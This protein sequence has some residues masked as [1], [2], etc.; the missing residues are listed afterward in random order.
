MPLQITD[1]PSLDEFIELSWH[2]SAGDPHWIPPMRARLHQELIGADAFGEYGRLQLFGCESGGRLAGRIVAL[3]NPRLADASGQVVGQVG[4]FEAIDDEQVAAGLFGAA[5]EWLRAAGAREVWG[6][7]NGGAHRT[8]RLMTSGFDRRPYLFE[9]RNPPYYP[10]LFERAGFE[11][12][13]SWY[14]IDVSSDQL[15]SA[16]ATL[17][18]FQVPER[19]KNAYD[20]VWLDPSD[21]RNV[22]SRLH[23]L[24]DAMWSGHLGYASLD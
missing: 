1:T 22:L 6:P 16:I 15:R 21:A 23:A 20:V 18:I 11:R 4:Y 7:M 9:P 17:P 24:L 8:H 5:F 3:L 14:S 10:R 19:A 13:Y 12:R 2:I